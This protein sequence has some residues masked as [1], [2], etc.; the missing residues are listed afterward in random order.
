MKTKECGNLHSTQNRRGESST[1]K[2][3]EKAKT[4]IWIKSTETTTSSNTTNTKNSDTSTYSIDFAR[5]EHMAIAFAA[6]YSIDY[7]HHHHRYHCSWRCC[8]RYYCYLH[9]NS[10]NSCRLHSRLLRRNSK[11]STEREKREKR[12]FFVW[13]F[14][15]W[16]MIKLFVAIMRDMIVGAVRRKPIGWLSASFVSCVRHEANVWPNRYDLL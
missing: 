16:F 1:H 12:E 3:K 6:K 7:L 14:S 15:K 10:R 13:F 2:T 9:W 8:C 11:Y 5:A 4:R